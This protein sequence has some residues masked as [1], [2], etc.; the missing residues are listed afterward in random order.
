MVSL[1]N[2][3][4]FFFSVQQYWQFQ[5]YYLT[6]YLNLNFF[7]CLVKQ[8]VSKFLWDKY[9][10]DLM[11]FTIHWDLNMSAHLGMDIIY[12]TALV[13]EEN[14]TSWRKE[15][16]TFFFLICVCSLGFI[17]FSFLLFFFLPR[18]MVAAWEAPSSK[19][20][21]KQLVLVEVNCTVRGQ[22]RRSEGYMINTILHRNCHSGHLMPTLCEHL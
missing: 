9:S 18:K 16:K 2:D 13:W 17:L 15:T 6:T 11:C 7:S 10:N 14:P 19:E 21:W 8:I 4:W 3:L 20:D 22:K 5:I 1:R 12:F